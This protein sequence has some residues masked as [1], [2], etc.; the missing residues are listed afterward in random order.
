MTSL[1]LFID[2]V[3]CGDSFFFFLVH[4]YFSQATTHASMMKFAVSTAS[5]RCSQS[6]ASLEV[7]GGAEILKSN[8]GFYELP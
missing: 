2:I 7:L 6:H 8:M 1:S 4:L 3:L 5:S